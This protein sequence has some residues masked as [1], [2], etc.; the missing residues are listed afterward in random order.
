PSGAAAPGARSPWPS[1]SGGRT[2]ADAR[3]RGVTR[4][5]HATA[6]SVAPDS[7]GPEV[8]RAEPG[9]VRQRPAASRI[10][11]AS[12]FRQVSL[13]PVLA[14]RGRRTGR[15][16]A[17]RG[18]G[19]AGPTRARPAVPAAPAA[20]AARGADTGLAGRPRR[21]RRGER[22]AALRQAREVGRAEPSSTGLR[23]R[24]PRCRPPPACLDRRPGGRYAPS[25]VTG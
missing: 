19:L 5:P 1:G 8:S 7:H 20:V 14:A 15:P 6:L 24:P 22:L 3:E 16:R 17:R 2:H 10:R 12:P 9:Q 23:P 21:R 4:S 13:R 11:Q 25:V 18:P